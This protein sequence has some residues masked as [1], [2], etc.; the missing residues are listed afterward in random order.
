MR[1]SPDQIK[2]ASEQ[3]TPSLAGPLIPL[4]PSRVLESSHARL[5][6]NFVGGDFQQRWEMVKLFPGAG[7]EAIEPLIS[8]LTLDKQDLELRWFTVKALAQFEHPRV[9]A[10]LTELINEEEEEEE[11]IKEI[12]QQS[13]ANMGRKVIETITPLLAQDSTRLSAVKSLAAIPHKD[14]IEPLLT[15]VDDKSVEVRRKAIEALASFSDSRLM[16][17]MLKALRD[18]DT[19][20]KKGA[21][22]AIAYLGQAHREIDPLECL[23]PLLQDEE[24]G[25]EAAVALGRIDTPVSVDKL[26]E[27]LRSRLSWSIKI[28]IVRALGWSEQGSALDYLQEQLRSKLA[29]SFFV[30]EIVHILGRKKNP[31]MSERAT[32]ILLNFYE[33]QKELVSCRIKQALAEAWGELG[34]EQ[35]LS[36][37]K[38]LSE[39][40][41]IKVRLHALTA[42]KKLPA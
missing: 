23:Y 12:A 11:E 33:E 17:L 34:D 18:E 42:L 21:I 28:K 31:S 36:F 26:G 16:P 30:Q 6:E 32:V 2:T 27:G 39:D 40:P 3:K 24:V 9:V 5:I 37:L 4:S 41:D 10:T 14:I 1:N 15:V 35:A 25:E 8:I 7:E 19:E 13:L 22:G 20:V 38:I 29:P